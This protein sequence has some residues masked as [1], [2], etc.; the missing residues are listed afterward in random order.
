MNTYFKWLLPIFVFSVI[1]AELTMPNVDSHGFWLG[2]TKSDIRTLNAAVYFYRKD[3]GRIP[4]SAEGL[5]GLVNSVGM[6]QYLDRLPVDPWGS[7]Y[8]YRPA[9]FNKSYDIYSAGPDGIDNEGK[10]DDVVLEDKRYNCELYYDCW[11]ENDYLNGVFVLIMLIS[12]ILILLVTI[13]KISAYMLKKVKRCS[14]VNPT[15]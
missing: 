12:F 15:L 2:K 8:I 4:G 14:A 9:D 13:F 10:G 5:S 6:N 1:G 11:S 7:N 3:H